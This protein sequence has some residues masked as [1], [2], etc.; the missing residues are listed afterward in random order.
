MQ[1]IKIE[2]D[3]NNVKKKKKF[4]LKRNEAIA[5][6]IFA[7]PA[8]LGLLI[9]TLAPMIASLFLSF[10]DYNAISDFN[11]VG[12]GNYKEVLFDDLFVKKSLIVTFIFA[13]GSTFF[14]LLGALI[15]AM[16]MNLKVKGQTFYR[17]IFYL[18]V[19][20]PA[21]AS[22]ILWLWL[23]NPDFGLLNS[24]LKFFHLPGS[25]WVFDES[26]AIPSLI[27]MAV[28]G[29]GGTA[30]IFLAGLQDVPIQL[31]EAVEVDGGNK[32]HKLRYVTIPSLTPIIFFNLIMGL[33]GSFQTFT[34][35]YVMTGGGPNNATLFY[36]LLIYRNA[37]EQNRFGYA[38]AL[39]WLLFIIIGLFT[40]FIFKTAKGWVFYGGDN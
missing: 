12:T 22:N 33:I 19:I 10:T 6:Y 36:S 17:T 9:W 31:L 21:V 2:Q 28:W 20:V 32:W 18:P 15:V 5:G 38:S 11:F 16:L 30:L 35:S 34:Q 1:N 13:L 40:L 25:N 26:T 37:F 24:I 14:T 8:I 39:A 23:F 29:C 4:S 3:I 27:L 7:M